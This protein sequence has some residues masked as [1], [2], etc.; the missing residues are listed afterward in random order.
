M[1]YLIAKLSMLKN[2]DNSVYIIAD[3]KKGVHDFLKDFSLKVN[4]TA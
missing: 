3:G 4:I 1:G 2:I